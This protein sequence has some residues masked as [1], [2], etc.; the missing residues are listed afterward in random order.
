MT[1]DE[2]ADREHAAYYAMGRADS[3]NAEDFDLA[4]QFAD[5]WGKVMRQYRSTGGLHP[6]LRPTY[7]E[8]MDRDDI[9]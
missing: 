6:G 1:S 5:F 2:A 4:F 9:Y 3:N 8:W 7:N